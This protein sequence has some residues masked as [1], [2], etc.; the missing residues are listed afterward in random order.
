MNPSKSARAGCIKHSG[1]DF[2]IQLRALP[3]DVLRLPARILSNSRFITIVKISQQQEKLVCSFHRRVE[4]NCGLFL[5]L[6]QEGH[7][8]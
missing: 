2:R 7:Q 4:D 3:P 5:K 8:D 1:S 6:F